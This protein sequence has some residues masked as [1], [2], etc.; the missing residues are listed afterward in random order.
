MVVPSILWLRRGNPHRRRPPRH[1]EMPPMSRL[2]EKRGCRA[3]LGEVIKLICFFFPEGKHGPKSLMYLNIYIYIYI[4]FF[5]IYICFIHIYIYIYIYRLYIQIVYI[6]IYIFQFGG[7]E[8]Y[9]L[10]C[11][12][13]KKNWVAF[14]DCFPLRLFS[15]L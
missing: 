3:G 2:R 8:G 9:N 12:I 4:C 11:F 1:R 6:Y 14:W 15:F 10:I 7:G 13:G 5:Y